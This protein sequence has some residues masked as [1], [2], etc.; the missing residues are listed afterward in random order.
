MRLRVAKKVYSQDFSEKE[1]NKAL[2]KRAVK[3]PVSGLYVVT[4]PLFAAGIMEIYNYNELLQPYYRKKKQSLRVYGIAKN[5]DE[6][7]KVVADIIDD[8]YRE[9]GSIDIKGLFAED[10]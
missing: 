3:R 4:E 6:A 9:L 7:K 5:R 2:R 8:A 10:S 1:F